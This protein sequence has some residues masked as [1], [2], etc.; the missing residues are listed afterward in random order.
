LREL[1]GAVLKKTR[2]PSEKPVKAEVEAGVVER[3][4]LEA[5]LE[6]IDKA[7]KE[8]IITPMHAGQLRERYASR[9][10]ELNQAFKGYMAEDTLQRLVKMKRLLEQEYEAKLH[11][12]EDQIKAVQENFNPTTVGKS[13]SSMKEA[14]FNPEEGELKALKGELLTA[15]ERLEAMDRV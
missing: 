7:L 5:T 9:W 14:R 15:I 4:V 11:Y 12:L 2:R 6:F 13:P 8:R 10:R 1:I 3:V